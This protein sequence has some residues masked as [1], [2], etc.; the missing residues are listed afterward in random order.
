MNQSRPEDSKPIS[1]A[2]NA[3]TA[4][5]TPGSLPRQTLMN[6]RQGDGDGPAAGRDGPLVQQPASSI[7]RQQ[8]AQHAA[9][10][11]AALPAGGARPQR[12]RPGRRSARAAWRRAASGGGP[13]RPAVF[14]PG[15]VC[16]SAPG[17]AL[18]AIP[19][20]CCSHQHHQAHFSTLHNAQVGWSVFL[21]SYP[22]QHCVCVRTCVLPCCSSCQ[23]VAWLPV[24][25][26]ARERH[27]PGIDPLWG[28]D[29]GGH[30]NSLLGLKL[31]N[32]FSLHFSGQ[33][34]QCLA[35]TWTLYHHLISQA[36][37]NRG[38]PSIYLS[39]CLWCIWKSIHTLG[40]HACLFISL[41]LLSQL[42]F[43]VEQTLVGMGQPV[44]ICA[45]AWTGW[46]A[47]LTHLSDKINLQIPS[48]RL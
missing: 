44:S 23:A 34:C 31:C 25:W 30:Y 7:P 18:Q 15:C 21:V 35:P 38:N 12:P 19:D 17:R 28:G 41:C 36:G 46:Q 14:A 20:P 1:S 45:I 32:P 2:R 8:Q 26:H 39:S 9:R 10:A 4:A 48:L 5:E 24:W 11:R 6:L 43:M 47:W 13:R 16:C 40:A 29:W 22:G 37:C 27:C 33:Q 3:Q 42:V